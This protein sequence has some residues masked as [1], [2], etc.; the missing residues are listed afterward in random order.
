[1]I[2]NPLKKLGRPGGSCPASAL[3]HHQHQEPHVMA[4]MAGES[5]GQCTPCR[6]GSWMG[7]L[8]E[9]L[10]ETMKAAGLCALGGRGLL[11]P[12]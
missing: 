8:L 1:M 11:V 9:R 2:A 12:S 10:G 4:F 7:E 6:L 5:S 3:G